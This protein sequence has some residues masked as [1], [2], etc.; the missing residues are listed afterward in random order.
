MNEVVDGLSESDMVLL[1]TYFSSRASAEMVYDA[2]LAEQGSVLYQAICQHCHGVDGKMS[3]PLYARIAGQRT[4]YVEMT[5][6]RFRDGSPLRTS[7]EMG[8]VSQGLSDQDIK[9]LAAYVTSL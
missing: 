6:R 1:A 7:Q 4:D 9:A 8:F 5:L 2:R 3:D